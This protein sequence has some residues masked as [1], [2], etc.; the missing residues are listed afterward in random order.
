MSPLKADAQEAQEVYCNGENEAIGS[1]MFG[2]DPDVYERSDPPPAPV[3]V[4]L[5]AKLTAKDR[6]TCKC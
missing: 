4:I 6:A 2:G 5:F 3:M 1:A